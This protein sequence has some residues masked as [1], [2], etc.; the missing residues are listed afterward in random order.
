MRDGQWKC[1]TTIGELP[2][3]KV[4]M[5]SVVIVGNS[6]T[7]FWQG[8]MVTPRGYLDKYPVPE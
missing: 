1:M 6:R 8:W 4:D 5:Q 3:D 7:Y 2:V